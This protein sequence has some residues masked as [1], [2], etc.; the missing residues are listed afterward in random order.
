MKREFTSSVYIIDEDRVLLI[1]HKKFQKWLSPGGHIESDETPP[2]AARREVLEE[3]GLEIEFITEENILIDQWN[4]KSFPR[5]YLCLL[6]EIP[7]YK[8]FPAHQHMDM[9]YV[10]KPLITQTFIA[11]GDCEKK[12]FTLTEIESLNQDIDIFKETTA[13]IKHLFQKFGDFV[14]SKT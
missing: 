10:A 4:A 7:A 5:P 2:E 1:Y 13:V 8:T 3:T 11:E 6:E 14:L 12:W 9:I